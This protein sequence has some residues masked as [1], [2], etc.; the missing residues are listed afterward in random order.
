[1]LN[2]STPL[3]RTALKRKPKRDRR[4]DEEKLYYAWLLSQPCID[5]PWKDCEERHHI[6]SQRFGAGT[7]LKPKDWFAIPITH[8]SH[9]EIHTK[10]TSGFEAEFGHFEHLIWGLWKA[11]GIGNVPREIRQR[12]D[13]FFLGE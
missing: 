3:K 5:A 2:R 4:P 13:G 12:L 8:E 6:R 11:Y 9:H 10:G 7:G 1:M